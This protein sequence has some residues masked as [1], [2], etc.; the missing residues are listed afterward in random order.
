V[1][2]TARTPTYARL[3]SRVAQF[4]SDWELIEAPLDGYEPNR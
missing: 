4:D 3:V 1:L 2:A